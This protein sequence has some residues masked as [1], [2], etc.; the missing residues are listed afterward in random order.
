MYGRMGKAYS[1]I[2]I[3]LSLL[4]SRL[5]DMSKLPQGPTI[6]AQQSQSSPS[7]NDHT[8]IANFAISSQWCWCAQLTASNSSYTLIMPASPVRQSCFW[9]S[10]LLDA[11]RPCQILHR[12]ENC[13]NFTH[14][15]FI[16]AWC[17]QLQCSRHILLHL[18]SGK[19]KTL[20]QKSLHCHPKSLSPQAN[21][22]ILHGD[23]TTFRPCSVISFPCEL[24]WIGIDFDLLWI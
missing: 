16:D 19:H 1:M 11:A 13:F 18:V 7:I 24:K 12:L 21:W 9:P 14:K 5:F 22:M 6:K 2:S 8:G 20:H 15:F 23:T 10:G 4:V 3:D 17:W